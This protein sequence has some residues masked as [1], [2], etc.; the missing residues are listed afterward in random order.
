MGGGESLRSGYGRPYFKEKNAI[1][2]EDFA[3]TSLWP[4]N[5]GVVEGNLHLID[6]NLVVIL[7]P[8]SLLLSLALASASRE[9]CMYSR[10]RWWFFLL[11]SNTKMSVAH[12]Y[13]IAVENFKTHNHLDYTKLMKVYINTNAKTI[14]NL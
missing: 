14:Y 11:C 10:A 6:V 9:A 3:L 5:F 2:Q 4:A 7:D 8:Q 12:A 13:N 1:S